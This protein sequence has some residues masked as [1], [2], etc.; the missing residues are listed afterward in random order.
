MT[1]EGI[2][3]SPSI[4]DRHP[5]L[6]EPAIKGELPNHLFIIPD[7]NG[8]W[9]NANG[10]RMPMR[11]ATPLLTFAGK[12]EQFGKLLSSLQSIQQ[13]GLT[14]PLMG[15]IAG[16][17]K[18]MATSRDLR[19]LPIKFFGGWA[20]AGGP[21]DNSG[22]WTRQP[23]SGIDEVTGLFLVMSYLLNTYTPE[24]NETNGI[25][26]VIGRRDRIPRY[27]KDDIEKAESLTENNTGQV[28]YLAIDYGGIDQEIREDQELFRRIT[29]GEIT[30]VSQI[31]PALRNSL[32][33]GGGAIPPMDLIIRT[34]GEQRISDL[35]TLAT[36]AEFYSEPKFFPD[37]K[38]EDIVKALIDYTNR[39]RRFGGRPSAASK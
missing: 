11:F 23:T 30:D 4:Y 21:E 39:D 38:T 27:L 25:F 22:N 32:L 29:A 18:F 13:R 35:G 28:I 1:S 20:F 6:R 8:R 16:V 34:S 36:N 5:E 7:G 2:R 3:P 37:L 15:H 14:S 9:A 10:L 12:N 31:T 19:E 17:E 33:D 24:I 26:K